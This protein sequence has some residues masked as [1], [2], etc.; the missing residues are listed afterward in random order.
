MQ[1]YNLLKERILEVENMFLNREIRRNSKIFICYEKYTC[2]VD[3][4][5]PDKTY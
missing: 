1:E 4:T 2:V 5:S 3:I